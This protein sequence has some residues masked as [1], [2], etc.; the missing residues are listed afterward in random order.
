MHTLVHSNQ[1]SK[2]ITPIRQT[3]TAAWVSFA[4]KGSIQTWA[5]SA[6]EREKCSCMSAR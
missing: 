6:E 2:H 3:A 1:R 5:V 4:A